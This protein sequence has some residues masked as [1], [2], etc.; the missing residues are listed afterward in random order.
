[1]ETPEKAR[2]RRRKSKQG[3]MWAGRSG[4]AS[5]GAHPPCFLW[6]R[7]FCLVFFFPLTFWLLFTFPVFL[8]PQGRNM[9]GDT[10]GAL[11]A[12]RLRA[13]THVRVCVRV[14]M[15]VSRCTGSAY[16]LSE[17]ASGCAQNEVLNRML[18]FPGD[19]GAARSS[20]CRSSARGRA[21][22]VVRSS[23]ALPQLGCGSEHL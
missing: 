22:R 21:E 5:L 19:A 12:W 3:L 15:Y 17:T 4:P 20:G 14:F 10:H 8:K 1:M 11:S 23:A 16:F 13:R 6:K 7:H 2:R 18:S 9:K